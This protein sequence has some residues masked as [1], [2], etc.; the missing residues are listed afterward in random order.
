MGAQQGKETSR[1][2]AGSGRQKSKVKDTKIPHP[3]ANIFEDHDGEIFSFDLSYTL[4]VEMMYLC[5]TWCS[6]PEVYRLKLRLV[7]VSCQI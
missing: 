7:N 3:S 6:K 2:R 1:D 5:C 4:M